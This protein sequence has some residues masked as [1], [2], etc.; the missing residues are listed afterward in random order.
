MA[1]DFSSW[2]R[3][4]GR[5]RC[6]LHVKE[7]RMEGTEQRKRRDVT[8]RKAH[9]KVLAEGQEPYSKLYLDPSQQWRNKRN[10]HGS[11]SHKGNG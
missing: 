11:S 10:K 9:Q 4:G 2:K 6:Q 7:R 1:A 8:G 3:G 5:E